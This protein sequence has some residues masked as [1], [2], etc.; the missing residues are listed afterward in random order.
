M[1][2]VIEHR[3]GLFGV[4]LLVFATLYGVAFATRPARAPDAVAAPVRARVESVTTVCPD[5]VRSR[6]SAVTPSPQKAP[7]A[8]GTG[9]ITI[10]EL[11][12]PAP[13][14]ADPKA[15]PKAADP[16]GTA[17]APLARLDRAGVLWRTERKAASGPL[18]VAGTGAM[19]SGLEA[20]QTSRILGGANRGLA[21]VRCVQPGSSA[22][23]VGPGPAAADVTLYL[24]NVD[25][26]AAS[27]E[28]AI[29]SGEGPVV[30]GSGN[31]LLLKPG[32]HRAIQLRDL[33]PSPLEMAVQ[34]A[35]DSGRVAVAAKAVLRGGKGVDWLPV[36]DEPAT[37]VVEP[38]LPGGGGLRTLYVAAPGEE[39]TVVQVKAVTSDGSYTMK[40]RES[41]DVPAG[42]AATLDVST[43]VGGQPSAIVLT[44]DVPI[45]AGIMI[46]GTGTRQD[47]AFSAGAAPIDIGSV[48]AD[49]RTGKGVTSRLILSAPVRQVRVRIQSI[50]SRG[51]APRPVEVTIPAAHTKEVTLAAPPGDRAFGVVIVPVA[52]SGPVYGGR[53]L[54][55]R[56]GQGLL[57]TIQP[58]APGR[59]QVTVPATAD[60]QSAV[61]P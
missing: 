39:D 25:R 43:G 38:V 44:A 6:V 45:V 30:G 50:P 17:P 58:L 11:K 18:T 27:V 40:S 55:E 37:R 49:D 33:A 7:A 9:A 35:T 8:R 14:A 13:G 52:G 5:P 53:V 36:A 28:I 16:A 41:M 26:A 12:A 61:L 32:E 20:A 60:T 15:G 21:G 19:A 31:G 56:T 10:T 57:L 42:S 22:W 24:A 23:F 59:T 48:V 4:V 1:K 46:T 2:A 34:V 54:D 3:L 51:A 47:V 29:Y